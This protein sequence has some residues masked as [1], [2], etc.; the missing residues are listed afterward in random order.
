MTN[1]FENQFEMFETSQWGERNDDK[2]CDSASQGLGPNIS[3]S[4]KVTTTI[5][6]VKS[7]YFFKIHKNNFI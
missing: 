6:D 3:W 2:K 7:I 5:E 4:A 1:K